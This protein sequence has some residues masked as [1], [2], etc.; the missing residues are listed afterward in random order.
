MPVLSN[1]RVS[2]GSGSLEL[3]GT[4]LELTI[5]VRVPAE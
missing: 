1:L 5:Q 4:D 2:V 3:V